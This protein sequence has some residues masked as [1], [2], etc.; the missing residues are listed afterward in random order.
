MTTT[1][2]PDPSEDT[3]GDWRSP[4]ERE[5]DIRQARLLMDQASAG[6]LRFESYLPPGLAEWILCFVERGTFVSPSEAVSVMLQEQRDLEPHPD[7]R[8]ETLKRSIEAA[9]NDPRP[10]L[11]HEEVFAF[12]DVKFAAP[13]PKPAVWPIGRMVQEP[14][15]ERAGMKHSEFQIGMEF[16]TG[17]GRWRVTD[18]G[19][20]TVL[21]IKLDQ[22]DP[23][24]YNGPC[25]ISSAVTTWPKV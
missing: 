16:L 1:H 20:R 25:W 6:G 8:R 12:L 14:P 23:R 17:S 3:S 5:A 13:R 2:S 15:L 10:R 24:N 19:T 9:I 11:S 7:L 22:A 4:E 18:I 21:A